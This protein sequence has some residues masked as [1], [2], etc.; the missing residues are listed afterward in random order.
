MLA[1]QSCAPIRRINV[2][3]DK[4]MANKNFT[5]SVFP[6]NDSSYL[7]KTKIWLLGKYFSGLMAVKKVDS[8]SYRMV[9]MNEMGIKF[10][11]LEFFENKTEEPFVVHYCMEIFNR[12]IIIRTIKKDMHALFFLVGP[13]VAKHYSTKKN[14]GIFRLKLHGDQYYYYLNSN[15]QIVKIERMGFPYKKA[16]IFVEEYDHLAPESITIDHRRINFRMELRLLKIN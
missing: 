16:E 15:Q 12:D 7:F 3:F 2:G 1:L 13:K 8:D 11:D 5:I 10:F 6:Q 14:E 9:F 4:E